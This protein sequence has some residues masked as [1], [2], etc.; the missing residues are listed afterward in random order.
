LL[1]QDNAHLTNDGQYKLTKL[2][3]NLSKLRET[4]LDH[5]S[6]AELKSRSEATITR[7]QNRKIKEFEKKNMYD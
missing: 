2:K 6:L 1:Y 7:A 4:K 3:E 5:L